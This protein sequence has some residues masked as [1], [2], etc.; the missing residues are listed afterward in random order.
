MKKSSKVHKK[1]K[2]SISISISINYRGV[3]SFWKWG[4]SCNTGSNVAWRLRRRHLLFSQKVGGQLPPLPPLYWRPWYINFCQNT[5]VHT[6][7]TAMHRASF[8][9]VY[10]GLSCIVIGGTMW[11]I[12]CCTKFGHGFLICVLNWLPLWL[13]MSCQ[14]A[15]RRQVWQK[16]KLF[17]QHWTSNLLTHGYTQFFQKRIEQTRYV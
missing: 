12:W 10:T 5:N 6:F 3:S 1:S 7:E 9:L 14:G 4:A 8:S 13:G 17:I 2:F 11:N 16:M 15:Q